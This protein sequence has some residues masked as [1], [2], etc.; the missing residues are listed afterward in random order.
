MS[1]V[2]FSQESH[3]KFDEKGKQAVI[4]FFKRNGY[5]HN[6]TGED[7]GID[8]HFSLAGFPD[9]FVEVAVRHLFDW[10]LS[11]WN[12]HSPWKTVHILK[13]KR[14]Y[15]NPEPQWYGGKAYLFELNRD[16]TEAFV[17]K[18]CELQE[19]HLKKITTPRGREWM[20]DVPVKYF[21]LVTL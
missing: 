16:M 13:R 8:L 19:K 17:I 6:V 14:K 18:P 9:V 1:S 10:P 4:N 5:A 11:E 12:K 21:R 15:G 3:D 7:R 20:Y 2:A